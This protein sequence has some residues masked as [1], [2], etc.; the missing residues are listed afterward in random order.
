MKMSDSGASPPMTGW[1]FATGNTR[2]GFGGGGAGAA[3]RSI[4]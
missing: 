1:M 3:G 4:S 2:N